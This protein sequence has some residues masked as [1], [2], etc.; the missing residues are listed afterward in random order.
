MSHIFI[1]GVKG[2]Y[3]SMQKWLGVLINISDDLAALL[4]KDVRAGDQSR[5]RKA[6]VGQDQGSVL[7]IAVLTAFQPGL[8]SH[9]AGVS[10]RAASVLTALGNALSLTK[11][12]TLAW[13]QLTDQSHTNVT[14]REHLSK[15]LQTGPTMVQND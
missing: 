2:S 1:H 13:E 4:L 14:L 11:H 5:R 10:H 3:E 12:G 15:L 6:G 8:L 9:D 7:V